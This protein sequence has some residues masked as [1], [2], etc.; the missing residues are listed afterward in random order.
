MPLHTHPV[1]LQCAHWE[2]EDWGGSCLLTLSFQ[3]KQRRFNISGNKFCK[4]FKLSKTKCYLLSAPAKGSIKQQRMAAGTVSTGM[5]KLGT[6]FQNRAS[7]LQSEASGQ[8]IQCYRHRLTPANQ[9][10]K[11]RKIIMTHILTA[12]IPNCIAKSSLQ[13]LLK[14]NLPIFPA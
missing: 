13:T 12:S 11:K 2:I 4:A 8:Y 10:R 7:P 1:Y 3:Y 9:K 6:I 5:Q 14:R